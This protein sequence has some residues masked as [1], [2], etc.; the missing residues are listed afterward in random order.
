MPVLDDV[1]LAA[2]R[3]LPRP[4]RGLPVL[5]FDAESD[6]IDTA[7]QR[8]PRLVVVGDDLDLARL[9][10]RLLRADRLDVEVGYVPARRTPGARVFRLPAG[11]RAA[12]RVRRGAAQPTPLIRDDAG[13]ALEVGAPASL[14]LYDPSPVRPFGA[15]DLHGLSGNSPYLGRELPGDVRWTFFRGA[16]TV[17]DGVLA[18]TMTA[19]EHA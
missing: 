16:A 3:A 9:L 4:L 19:G 11:W 15:G 6:Q 2:G 8:Y 18:E 5:P 14:T 17:S 12:R 7:I 1:L 10:T 13:T